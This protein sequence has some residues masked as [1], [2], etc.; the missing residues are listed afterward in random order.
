[1][2]TTGHMHVWAPQTSPQHVW[3]PQTSPQH[4]WAPQ[5]SPQRVWAPQTSPHACMGTTNIT[6]ACMGTTNITTA[7]G[8][9]FCCTLP[10]VLIFHHQIC[11][12]LLI[13]KTAC[14]G[15]ITWMVWEY[16]TLFSGSFRGRRTT[17][18]RQE[19]MLLFKYGSRLLLKMGTVLKLTMLYWSYVN[20]SHI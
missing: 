5:T 6:T 12:C 13:G 15:T 18:T 8:Q 2:T 17:F 7:L 10:T 1:M 16:R 4:V 11:T 14:K 20:L 9:I 19:Y 3:T